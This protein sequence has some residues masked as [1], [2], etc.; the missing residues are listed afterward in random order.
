MTYPQKKGIC[1]SGKDGLTS[2][3]NLAEWDSALKT[4]KMFVMLMR[5]SS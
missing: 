1:G 4:K 2:L 5:L 3:H